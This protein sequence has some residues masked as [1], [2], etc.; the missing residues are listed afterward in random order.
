MDV[1]GA[2]VHVDR[3]HGDEDRL[4]PVANRRL[5][6]ARIPEARLEVLEGVGHLFLVERSE[7]SARLV[8]DRV[9]GH[10]SVAP[11]Q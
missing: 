10:A 6:A 11:A 3:H 5:I 7:R 1:N 4:L 8:R 9:A 2:P